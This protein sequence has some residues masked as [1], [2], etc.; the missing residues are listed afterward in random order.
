MLNTEAER[1]AAADRALG[2]LR[3]EGLEPDNFGTKLIDQYIKG[4]ITA[5]QAIQALNHRSSTREQYANKVA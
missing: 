5:E 4:T 2:D 3:L 1:K